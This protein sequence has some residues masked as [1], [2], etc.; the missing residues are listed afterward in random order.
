M[1]KNKDL[2]TVV[3][4]IQKSFK[5]L[6]KKNNAKLIRP[7]LPVKYLEDY[8]RAINASSIYA[9]LPSDIDSYENGKLR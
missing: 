8:S 9:D 4:K 2:A 7:I 1:S 3:E 6:I 5:K